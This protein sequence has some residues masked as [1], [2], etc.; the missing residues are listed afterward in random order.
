[1]LFSFISFLYAWATQQNL[2]SFYYMYLFSIY[3]T[4]FAHFLWKN[5]SVYRLFFIIYSQT[6]C[7]LCGRHC[8]R[9]RICLND[10]NNKDIQMILIVYL[11]KSGHNKCNQVYMIYYF[12]QACIRKR[13][14]EYN[15]LFLFIF[16]L[17]IFV[18]QFLPLNSDLARQYMQPL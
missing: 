14:N 6:S 3:G 2:H 5:P 10:Y 13:M 17:L 9:V 16:L 15:F 8:I 12:K 1:M 18:R 4:I 11:Q 7:S